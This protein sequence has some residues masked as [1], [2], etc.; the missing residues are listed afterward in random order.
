M[1]VGKP[2]LAWLV[3][4]KHELCATRVRKTT[5]QPKCDVRDGLRAL[6]KSQL[7]T[8][9]EDAEVVGK[10]DLKPSHSTG[11]V[12]IFCYGVKRL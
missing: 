2:V 6:T 3:Q 8:L 5:T 7:R 12:S 1:D 4:L 9:A 11:H 10:E